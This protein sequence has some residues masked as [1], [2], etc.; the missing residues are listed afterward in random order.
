MFW[1]TQKQA[2]SSFS[3]RIRWTLSCPKGCRKAR[4][5][6]KFWPLCRRFRI[7]KKTALWFLSQ[8]IS[9]CA[10][11]RRRWDLLQ[12]TIFLT[13]RSMT[14]TCSTPAA[15]SCL[16][17]F[18]TRTARRCKAGR[19]TAE[20][21][22]KSPVPWCASGLRT[23]LFTCRTTPLWRR[24]KRLKGKRPRFAL[25]A[26]TCKANTPS[27]ASVRETASSALRLTF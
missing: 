16:K 20:L 25:C 9:T 26:T 27:G 21:G 24:S 15:W 14:P 19:K 23:F 8:K 13:K 17:T 6:T 1:D 5:T 10:L 4:P 2:E 22:T 7:E 3:K 18:G 11:K 12:K